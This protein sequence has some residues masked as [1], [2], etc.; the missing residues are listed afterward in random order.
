M[1]ASFEAEKLI[2][3]V[4]FFFFLFYF[5]SF[6][7]GIMGTWGNYIPEYQWVDFMKND[8]FWGFYAFM[9]KYYIL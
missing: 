9:L 7:F 8:G 4:S 2:Q 5:C 6:G 1:R 3:M